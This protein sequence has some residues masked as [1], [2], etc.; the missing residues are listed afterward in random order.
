[1]KEEERKE[2]RKVKKGGEEGR[3][4][5]RKKSLYLRG[6]IGRIKERMKEE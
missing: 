6:I 4:N 1:M 5:G 2:G 3:R